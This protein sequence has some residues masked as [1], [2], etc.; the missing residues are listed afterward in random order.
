VAAVRGAGLSSGLGDRLAT[1]G[2]WLGY[3]Q[4]DWCGCRAEGPPGLRVGRRP[5]GARVWLGCGAGRC[6]CSTP[7]R[8]CLGCGLDGRLPASPGAWWV[9]GRPTGVAVV[10]RRCLSC[11]VSWICCGGSGWVR[12]RRAVD[13]V[14]WCWLSY[15]QAVVW[16]EGAWL[17]VQGPAGL[18]P[19]V[20]RCGGVRPGCGAGGCGLCGGGWPGSAE[21]LRQCVI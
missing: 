20:D 2:V 16:W 17:R 6:G 1:P 11:W 10:L 19:V 13:V 18:W 3:G 7:Y 5:A 4:A 21:R 15:G 12:G 14:P 9:P 8:P